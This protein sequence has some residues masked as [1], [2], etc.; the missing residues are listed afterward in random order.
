MVHGWISDPVVHIS[1][2]FCYPAKFVFTNDTHVIPHRM[3][4]S[5][6]YVMWQDKSVGLSHAS[7]VVDFP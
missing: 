5:M 4:I 7:N 6:D 2:N 1:P 3:C